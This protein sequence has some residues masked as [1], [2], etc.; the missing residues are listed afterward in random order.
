MPLQMKHCGAANT[1]QPVNSFS[2]AA[3]AH[4]F[5]QQKK[6]TAKKKKKN[7]QKTSKEQLKL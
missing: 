4:S 3:W 7:N 6:E 5:Y 2:A 1:H